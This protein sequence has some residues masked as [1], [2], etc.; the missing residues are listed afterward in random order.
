[1]RN[2]K[3]GDV[4]LWKDMDNFGGFDCGIAVEHVSSRRIKVIWLISG[5]CHSTENEKDFL[6][7]ECVTL[8][9]RI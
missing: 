7:N 8:L 4:V 2:L 1:M 9:S 6:N 3:V 5:E